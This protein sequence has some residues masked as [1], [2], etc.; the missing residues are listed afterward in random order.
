MKK[1]DIL[2]QSILV[3]YRESLLENESYGTAELIKNVIEETENNK[4]I[5]GGDTDI[6]SELI[7]L[8]NTLLESKDNAFSFSFIFS[9]IV[10][11]IFIYI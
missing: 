8:I 9:L 6:T 1:T 10:I 2:L 4:A 7:G 11:Y 5:I 3:L